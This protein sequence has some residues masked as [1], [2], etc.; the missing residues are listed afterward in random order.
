MSSQLPIEQTDYTVTI[1]K[2]QS[3]KDHVFLVPIFI[4][5]LLP[6]VITSSYHN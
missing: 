1:L 2:P 5:R 3:P 6:V 4:L